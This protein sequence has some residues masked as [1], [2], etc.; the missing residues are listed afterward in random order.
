[1]STNQNI[2]TDSHCQFLMPANFSTFQEIPARFLP[3]SLYFF[4]YRQAITIFLH[5]YVPVFKTKEVYMY[6]RRFSSKA[7]FIQ[8]QMRW[9]PHNPPLAQTSKLPIYPSLDRLP[10]PEKSPPSRSLSGK[11]NAAGGTRPPLSL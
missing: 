9:P 6:N 10:A 7:G 2:D 3:F 11:R 4:V 8:A 5:V 1:M